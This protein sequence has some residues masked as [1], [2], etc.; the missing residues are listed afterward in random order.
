M[1][2]DEIRLL[3][4][5]IYLSILQT[6]LHVVHTNYSIYLCFSTSAERY[7]TTKVPVRK[8]LTTMISKSKK[9]LRSHY[10]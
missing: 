8:R 1:D 2:L 7:I 3:S 9:Y 4:L 6:V 10:L 5:I